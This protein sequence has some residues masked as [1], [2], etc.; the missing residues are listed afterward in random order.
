MGGVRAGVS[1]LA[2][3]LMVVWGV[4]APAEEVVELPSGAVA[5]LQE[6]VTDRPGGGLVYR[7]RF[8][9]D[10]FTAEADKLE[11]VMGDMDHL[12][13]E[14]AL[15]RVPAVG[16]QPSLIIISLASDESPFGEITPGILQVFEAYSI[17]NGA[18]IWEAF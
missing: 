15:P 1:Y 9:I 4:S 3:L 2:V 8:V 18:C 10:G 17:E 11:M 12:C 6:V 7:F 5:H 16:P 13:A 14:Y